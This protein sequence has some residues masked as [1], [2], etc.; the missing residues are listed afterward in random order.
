MATTIKKMMIATSCKGV[1]MLLRMDS[2][3][4]LKVLSILPPTAVLMQLA[5]LL[6]PLRALSNGYQLRLRNRKISSLRTLSLRKHLL[7]ATLLVNT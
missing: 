5:V 7:V 3:K 1:T 2:G 4:S 6:I